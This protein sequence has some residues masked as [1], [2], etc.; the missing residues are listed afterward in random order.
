MKKTTMNNTKKHNFITR[1]TAIMMTAITLISFGMTSITAEASGFDAKDIYCAGYFRTNEPTYQDKNFRRREIKG[2]SV[3]Y[4]NV[5]LGIQAIFSDGT[6]GAQLGNSSKGIRV[7]VKLDENDY[8][9]GITYNDNVTYKDKTNA[10]AN[11][12]IYTK[13]GKVYGAYGTAQ[14][15]NEE[16]SLKDAYSA[17]GQGWRA[18]GFKVAIPKNSNYLTGIGVMFS[19]ELNKNDQEVANIE[20]LEKVYEYQQREERKINVKIDLGGGYF[21]KK[22]DFYARKITGIDINGNYILGSWEK[23]REVGDDDQSFWLS[24]NYVEFGYSFDIRGGTNWPYSGI[25]W[26]GSTDEIQSINITTGGTC[27]NASITIKVDGKQVLHHGN[28]AS[29]GH[30]NFK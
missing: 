14:G 4:D 2:F 24:A 17:F 23:I 12:K 8:I 27:R 10:I 13:N 1:I 20:Y 15:G 5:V 25:F 21:V 22:Q 3:N 7:T 29:H 18:V 9:T 26:K 11:L 19:K 28:C 6:T 16:I 30:Y